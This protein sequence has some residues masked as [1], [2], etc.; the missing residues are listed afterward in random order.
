MR[1]E[2]GLSGGGAQGRRRR[3]G[4]RAARAFSR[5]SFTVFWLR[6]VATAFHDVWLPEGSVWKSFGL[7]S[8]S[9]P[10]ISVEIPKGRTPPLCV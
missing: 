1:R 10:M 4:R 3:R 6:P 7:P 2:G 5:Y 9:K 8:V